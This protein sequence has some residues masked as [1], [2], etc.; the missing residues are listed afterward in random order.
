IG[1]GGI[2]SGADAKAKMDAGASLVQLYSGL[3]YAGPALVRE[4]ARAIK[5]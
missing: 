1:V 2:M 4:C 3:I 5:Q